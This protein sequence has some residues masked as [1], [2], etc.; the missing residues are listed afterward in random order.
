MHMATP[1]QIA[2]NIASGSPEHRIIRYIVKMWRNR[3]DTEWNK[4]RFV[5]RIKDG[6]GGVNVRKIRDLFVERNIC[7]A[8]EFDTA[9]A[10]GVNAGILSNDLRSVGKTLLDVNDL[11]EER[12]LAEGLEAEAQDQANRLMQFNK[13]ERDV[14][15]TDSRITDRAREIIAANEK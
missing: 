12:V 4:N 15:K 3:N 5:Q 14:Y 7:T 13:E 6:D 10:R 1:Q 11:I 2:N 9:I 8:D